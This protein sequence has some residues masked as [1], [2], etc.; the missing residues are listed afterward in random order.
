M[1]T[2]KNLLIERPHTGGIDGVQRLYLFKDGH[3]LSLLNSP[4]LHLYRFA[5]EAAVIKG[6]KADGTWDKIDYSTVLTEDVAVFA[7]DDEANAFIELAEKLF[8]SP[9]NSKTAVGETP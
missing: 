5:W 3:G 9:E 8:G 2:D 7:D 4:M 6:L 1:L